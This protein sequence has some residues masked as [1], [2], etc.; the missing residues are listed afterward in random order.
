MF[1]REKPSAE[2]GVDPSSSLTS[3]PRYPLHHIHIHINIHIH[4]HIHDHL[5]TVTTNLGSQ[6]QIS[7]EINPKFLGNQLHQLKT[8]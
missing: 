3:L 8:Y 1:S 4:I 5:S 6:F 2:E 7:D